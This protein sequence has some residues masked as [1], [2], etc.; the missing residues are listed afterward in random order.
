V[1]DVAGVNESMGVRIEPSGSGRPPP[2][3]TQG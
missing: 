1:L 2:V 3:D